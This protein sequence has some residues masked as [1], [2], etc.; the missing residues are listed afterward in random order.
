MHDMLKKLKKKE[1]DMPSHEKKAKMD[2]LSHLRDMAQESMGSK[3]HGM[4]KVSVMSDSPEGLKE[5]LS[6]AQN[7]MEHK[8][9]MSPDHMDL[10]PHVE[11][12]D[13][14]EN[15]EESSQHEA[16]ESPEEESSEHELSPEEIDAQIA[17][18]VSLKH[19]MRKG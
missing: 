15:L 5:G 11:S 4:K 18:L 7:I 19:S 12:E 10:S 8:D 2:V 9:E 3:L 14:Y 16:S 17:H 13:P 1:S 6:K